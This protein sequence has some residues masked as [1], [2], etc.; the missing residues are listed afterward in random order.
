M[1]K[2]KELYIQ[3][4]LWMDEMLE[5]SKEKKQKGLSALEI[6]I[7]AAV[8]LGVIFVVY[9]YLTGTL[10]NDILPAMGTKIKDFFK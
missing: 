7:Y 8:S 9:T 6:T 2:M 10:Q 1:N 4:N 5:K 3:A